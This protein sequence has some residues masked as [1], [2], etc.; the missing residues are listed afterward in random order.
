MGSSWGSLHGGEFWELQAGLGILDWDISSEI[1][2]LLDGQGLDDVD[3]F[4]F[5]TVSS[6]HLT[7][8]IGNGIA[9][10]VGGNL[11]VHVDNTGGGKILE[12]DSI[13]FD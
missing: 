3:I 11:S 8:D 9:E 6:S 1:A 7:V 10:G 13:Y 4:S 2:S 12:D 5:G